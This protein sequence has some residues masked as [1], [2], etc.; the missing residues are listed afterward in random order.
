MSDWSR[1]V[2]GLAGLATALGLAWAGAEARAQTTYTWTTTGGGSWGVDL[3]WQPLQVAGGADNTADFGT[4][5][6]TG[7]ATVTLDTSRTIGHLTFG[8]TTPSH[9]WTISAGSP[10]SST[11]T[12]DVSGGNA[13]VTVTNQTA[14]IGA[15]IAGSDGLTK[16]GPG[17]LV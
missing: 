3:N 16:A 17:T 8:D 12:L 7:G 15:V 13:T 6:L 10:T 5:N 4:V 9:N 2:R 11:L 14:T 1:T